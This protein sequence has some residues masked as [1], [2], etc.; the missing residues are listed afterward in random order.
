MIESHE[1]IDYIKNTAL[2]RAM[3]SGKPYIQEEHWI[4]QSYLFELDFL[5]KNKVFMAYYW[6]LLEDYKAFIGGAATKNADK[7]NL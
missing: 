7:E 6:E 5:V 1:R 4:A 2:L 3:K